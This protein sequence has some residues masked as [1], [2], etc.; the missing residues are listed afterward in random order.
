MRAF[1][2]RYQ[3]NTVL[4]TV[5]KWIAD[6]IMAIVLAYALVL[7]T[8]GRTTIAGGSMQPAIQNAD[9]VLINRMAYAFVHPKRYSVVAFK[10]SGVESSRIY[11][12]R[13]IGLPGET[14][15]IKDGH[16]YIDGNLLENDIVREDI[17]TAGLAANEIHLG[18]D[19]YFVLGDNRNNSEDSRF[20][21]IGTVKE[22]NIIGS[23]WAI[24]DP[25]SRSGLIH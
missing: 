15:Q 13:I 6:M 9:T 3:E 8:C 20:A 11:V 5:C 12:K 17:L 4:L 25:I 1:Q 18:K 21:N 24:M 7:F 19:E 16:V 23:V 2:R 10:V 22:E 14:V